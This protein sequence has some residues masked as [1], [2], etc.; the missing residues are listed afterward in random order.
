MNK[1][2]KEAKEAEEKRSLLVLQEELRAR[3]RRAERS[4]E[5]SPRRVCATRESGGETWERRGRGEAKEGK[6]RGAVI[7]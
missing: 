3:P 5:P 7:D 4:A 2:R 1:K 6:G